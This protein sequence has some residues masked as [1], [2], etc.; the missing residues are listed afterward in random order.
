MYQHCSC[1]H[2]KG[3]VGCCVKWFCALPSR[4]NGHPHERKSYCEA[5]FWV[6]AERASWYT[7]A[8]C[9]W[10]YRHSCS[11]STG[12]QKTQ[13]PIQRSWYQVSCLLW[14]ACCSCSCGTTWALA[15]PRALTSYWLVGLRQFEA[16]PWIA[17]HAFAERSSDPFKK[18]N[19]L[20]A[21][22]RY[23]AGHKVSDPR[24]SCIWK[25][26]LRNRSFPS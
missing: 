20:P 18:D 22:C 2:C 6:W 21:A 24:V 7:Q 25:W 3:G 13:W 10:A 14:R 1:N 8:P 5:R 16:S 11:S 4:Y 23:T 9:V 26:R 15:L 19:H 12:L 17:L